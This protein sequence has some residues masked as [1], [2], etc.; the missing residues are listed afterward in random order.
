MN[1]LE[2]ANVKK[3]AATGINP[4]KDFMFIETKFD[5]Y[6]ILVKLTLDGRFVGI[7]QIVVDT[8]FRTLKERTSTAP[9]DVDE[10]PEE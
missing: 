9:I 5:K 1:E 10:L 6:K 3:P 4:E 2:S 8:D 7:E